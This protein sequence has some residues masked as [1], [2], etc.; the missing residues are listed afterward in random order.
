MPMCITCTAFVMEMLEL[1]RG[2]TSVKM[3]IG[4]SPRHVSTT[5]HRVLRGTGAFV[6]P[7]GAVC[8]MKRQPETCVYTGAPC[9]E[10]NRCICATGRSSVQDEEKVSDAVHANPSS[11]TQIACGTGLSQ[12]AVWRTLHKAQLYHFH[13]QLAQALQAGDNHLLLHLCRW[14][15]HKI[16][17]QP[18]FLCCVLWIDE[19]SNV[20]VNRLHRLRDWALGNPHVARHSSFQQRSSSHC[21]GWNRSRLPN[22]TL[23]E[24][25][26]PRWNPVRWFSLKNNSPLLED[27]PLNVREDTCF[28][29]DGAHPH[30]SRQPFS[31]H[32]DRPWR[33][34]LL[35]ST[36]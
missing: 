7:A 31:W 14:L 19:G 25:E 23:R 27:A 6:P 22:R 33:S 21:L 8:R 15:L 17:D 29:H 34:D 32:V 20:H 28:Q 12:S 9:S 16:V 11:S 3:Q 4:G 36:H 30:F 10:G 24:S 18:Y 35:A 2:N 26:S 1:Q 5:A 13:V